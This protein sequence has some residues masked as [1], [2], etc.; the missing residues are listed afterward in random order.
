VQVMDKCFELVFAFDEV[1][2]WGG[3]RES[4]SLQQ[5][6][7]N[8]VS[9]KQSMTTHDASAYGSGTTGVVGIHHPAEG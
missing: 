7:T 4:I 3:Y 5:I 6:K 8:M 9:N 2:S 1:I